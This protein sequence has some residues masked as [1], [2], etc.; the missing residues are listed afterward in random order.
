MCPHETP[1]GVFRYMEHPALG[2]PVQQRYVRAVPEEGHEKLSESWNISP[3]LFRLFS[4]ERRRLQA[5]LI[6]ALLERK[7]E[8]DPLPGPAVTGQG[9]MVLL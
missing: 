9:A 5:H 6:V 8:R 4:M 2:T 3:M 7:M 1:P